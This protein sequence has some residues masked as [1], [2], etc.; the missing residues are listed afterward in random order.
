MWLQHLCNLNFGGVRVKSL[1]LLFFLLPM[2]AFGQ[3]INEYIEQNG[4]KQ[5]YSYEF[6]SGTVIGYVG[7]HI[8]VIC[9]TTYYNNNLPLAGLLISAAASIAEQLS[10]EGFKIQNTSAQNIKT[11]EK[12]TFNF[13]YS[14]DPNFSQ[15]SANGHDSSEIATAL[16][17]TILMSK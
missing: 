2:M 13:N 4:L 6:D 17:Y 10:A 16:I 12:S 11:S 14:L 9:A 15:N 3:N 7:S 5:K 8:A 1:C